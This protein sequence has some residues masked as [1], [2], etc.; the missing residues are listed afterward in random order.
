MTKAWPFASGAASRRTRTRPSCCQTPSGTK[1][2][3]FPV[4]TPPTELKSAAI[5]TAR[6]K[7]S[8]ALMCWCPCNPSSA[9]D[10]ADSA[11]ADAYLRS[12]RNRG[13]APASA[14]L[15]STTAPRERAL[16]RGSAKSWPATSAAELS[17]STPL[18]LNGAVTL[19]AKAGL[20]VNEGT[21]PEIPAIPAS[22]AYFRRPGCSETTCQFHSALIT[23]RERPHLQHLSRQSHS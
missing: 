4:R 7:K 9:C 15:I 6:A 23:S 2:A 1:R 22:G 14:V 10:Q 19:A 11:T 16:T 21:G 8:A 13:L 5:S 3:C 17:P 18:T 12:E 20:S